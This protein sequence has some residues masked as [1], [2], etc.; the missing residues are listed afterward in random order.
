MGRK[1]L[2]NHY[3]ETE[4]DQHLEEE[5]NKF[6]FKTKSHLLRIILKQ[7][8]NLCIYEYCHAIALLN[9]RCQKHIYL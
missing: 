1:L 2:R 9:G 3:W 8:Y 4:L 6:G 5:K 7:R